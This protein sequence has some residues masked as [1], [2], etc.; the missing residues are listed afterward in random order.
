MSPVLVCFILFVGGRLSSVCVSV[1]FFVDIGV[2]AFTL[3]AFLSRMVAPVFVGFF[4]L[5]VLLP[6]LVAAAAAFAALDLC[7][8][9][10][11]SVYRRVLSIMYK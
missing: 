11:F 1:L 7:V 9:T 2:I 8:N 6:R 10:T 4:L 3:L 5:P